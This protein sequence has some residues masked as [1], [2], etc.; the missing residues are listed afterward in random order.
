MEL[1]LINEIKNSAKHNNSALVLFGSYSRGDFDISSD[2]DV[3][4][5]TKEKEKPYSKA[6]INFSTYSLDQLKTMASEGNLFVLHLIMEGKVISGDFNILEILK[7]NFRKPKSYN[8]FRNEI[9]FTAKLLD[10]TEKKFKANSK[11]YYGLLCYLFRSYLYAL[12]YDDGYIDFS[13]KKI[14]A[15]YKDPDIY[16]V[17]NLKY[18][19]KITFSEY[20]YCKTVFQK[21]AKTEFK[22]HLVDPVELLRALQESSKFGFNIALHFLE[23]L[24]QE[25]Y[26]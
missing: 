8:S 24:V 12:M 19:T 1:S 18:N 5:V 7:D 15:K 13:I 10:V 3:L 16:K 26:I 4:E 9:I 22:N 2:I 25:I 20:L 14:S 23:D 21:Y 17:F 6:K 11:G